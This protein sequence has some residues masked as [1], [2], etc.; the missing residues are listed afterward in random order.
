VPFLVSDIDACMGW[1]EGVANTKLQNYFK[2][3]LVPT[4]ES[5]NLKKFL[6]SARSFGIRKS[7]FLEINGFQENLSLTA[8]DSLF[9]FQMKKQ[10]YKLG[11]SP[12][13]IAFWDLPQSSSDYWK[14]VYKYSKGDAETGFLFWDHYFILFNEV[15]KG[16]F[17]L[18]CVISIGMF[19]GLFFNSTNF[20]LTLCSLFLFIRIIFYF[21][22]FGKITQQNYLRTFVVFLHSSAQAFGFTR[23][24]F[25]LVRKKELIE[26]VN[27]K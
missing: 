23:G 20:I 4:L 21:K 15:L 1:Y 14:K 18:L 19:L 8:E 11:F 24:L 2:E 9:G 6:P 3:F 22:R 13:A 12:D 26:L 25:N 5:L 17:D 16:I 10:N 27:Q 7:K